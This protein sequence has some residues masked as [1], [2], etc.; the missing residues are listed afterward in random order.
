MHGGTVTASSDGEGQGSEFVVRLPL[1]NR[2]DQRPGPAP[3]MVRPRPPVRDGARIVVVEDNEDSRE[4][5]CEL[6]S[7][8]GYDCHVAASGTAGLG[9][10]NELR[11]D[12]VILDLG[13]PEVDGFRWRAAFVTKL[14]VTTA[15]A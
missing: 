6:L 15:C 5:M 10:V 13:L 7:T 14:D 9:L 2:I 1:A 8:E 4:L 3:V 12:V 11:P